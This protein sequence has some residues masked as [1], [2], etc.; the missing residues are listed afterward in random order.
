[1]A[2]TNLKVVGVVG[3]SNLN[4][5]CT[6]V[7][8]N[9]FVCNNGDF[10]VNKRNDKCLADN[11]LVSFIL[12]VNC[13][14]SIAKHSFGTCGSKFKITASVLEGVLDVPEMACLFLVFNLGI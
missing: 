9:V 1:M 11:V 12:G 5:T 4:Y 3:R 8:F 7:H 2:L 13:N 6:E 10:T 14:S